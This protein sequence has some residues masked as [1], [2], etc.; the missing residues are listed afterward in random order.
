MKRREDVETA[1]L[2][3]DDIISPSWPTVVVML[4]RIAPDAPYALRIGMA[5]LLRRVADDMTLP[6][7]SSDLV[8]TARELVEVLS[9]MRWG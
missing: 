1:R 2:H 5:E 3:V 8:K 6:G 9:H 7:A 4:E